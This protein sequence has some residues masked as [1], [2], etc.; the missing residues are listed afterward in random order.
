MCLPGRFCVSVS[1]SSA[2]QEAEPP[3]EQA[4]APHQA[5]ESPEAEEWAEGHAQAAQFG[6]AQKGGRQGEGE[7]QQSG[8]GRSGAETPRQKGGDKRGESLNPR[9][10]QAYGLAAVGT[11]G[12]V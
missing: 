5:H 2:L 3:E 6:A 1:G 7:G 8:E 10:A 12:A 9:V 11:A 4:F